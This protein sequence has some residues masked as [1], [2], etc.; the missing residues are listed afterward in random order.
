MAV[1]CSVVHLWPHTMQK[2]TYTFTFTFTY[3]PLSYHTTPHHIPPHHVISHR[4]TLS[5]P[6]LLLFRYI[7]SP[8]TQVATLLSVRVMHAY[9]Y[10]PQGIAYYLRSDSFGRV[11]L[12]ERLSLE[13]K[14]TKQNDEVL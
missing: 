6:I 8:T 11:S 1:Q 2:S 14:S 13:Y 5:R 4:T 12:G 10:I 7:M 3:I 9:V